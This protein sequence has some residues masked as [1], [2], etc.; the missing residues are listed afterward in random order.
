MHDN[1]NNNNNKRN[2]GESLKLLTKY[3]ELTPTPG[4]IPFMV[5]FGTFK[6]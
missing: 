5:F 4:N 6:S 1:G 2:V 3:E